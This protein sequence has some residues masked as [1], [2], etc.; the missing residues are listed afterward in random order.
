MISSSSR[1][2]W[3]P[4]A[5][6][7]VN[8]IAVTRSAA[9]CCAAA[10]RR[11][12]VDRGRAPVV[13]H[14]AFLVARAGQRALAEAT[15]RKHLLVLDAEI[16]AGEGLAAI[17]D[18]LRVEF[19]ARDRR[20][21]VDIF[22]AV[23]EPFALLVADRFLHAFGCGIAPQAKRLPV[24]QP[25]FLVR[26]LDHAV[27]ILADEQLADMLA[28]VA[29]PAGMAVFVDQLLDGHALEAER[30]QR[31]DALVR[32]IGEAR[33]WRVA[34]EE[35]P[36]AD[37]LEPDGNVPLFHQLGVAGDHPLPL[38]ALRD[39]FAFEYRAAVVEAHHRRFVEDAVTA[40]LALRQG[41]ARRRIQEFGLAGQEQ[42][43]DLVPQPV[44]I[45]PARLHDRLFGHDL[46]GFDH[47]S[48]P[49]PKCC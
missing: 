35:E 45:G 25:E 13:L 2:S 34:E 22:G 26:R 44:P 31:G 9:I 18:A 24:G 19:A 7:A 20:N 36:V 8:S 11:K 15:D 12:H 14:R 21:A 3:A 41:K 38:P 6:L 42:L 23:V 37:V 29:Q 4:S 33:I 48:C 47:R 40:Q 49:S 27:R 46:T 28:L 30:Q 16:H 10:D 39:D 1:S 17:V 32:L 43:R 5:G